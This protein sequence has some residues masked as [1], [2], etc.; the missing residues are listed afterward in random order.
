MVV[1][2]RLLFVLILAMVGVSV[3][4]AQGQNDYFA[5]E[6]TTPLTNTTTPFNNNESYTTPYADAPRC[7]SHNPHE[8][9]GLWDPARGCHYDHEHKH[10][11]GILY[12][13]MPPYER[14]EAQAMLNLFGPPGE[15]FGGTSISY[16]WQT[17]HGSGPDYP[18]RPHDWNMH[19]NSAKHGGYGWLVRY[20]IPN[21]AGEN[22]EWVKDFRLQYHAIMGTPGALVRYH[23]FTLEA[24]VCIA[25]KGC[26]LMR[27]GGWIDYGHLI[28]NGETVPLDGQEGD[29]D[30]RRLFYEVDDTPSFAGEAYLMPTFWYGTSSHA[31]LTDHPWESDRPFRKLVIGLASKDVWGNIHADDPAFNDLFCPDYQCNK[32]GSTI[33]AHLLHINLL[34]EEFNGYVDRY[35]A[36]NE[37]CGAAGLDCIPTMIEPGR[38]FLTSYRDDVHAGYDALGQREFDL[39]PPGVWW[40]EFPN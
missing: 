7:P 10:N 37:A 40:I 2:K 22:T 14:A 23:S 30:R 6:P 1:T 5:Y 16:P 15:W 11:P 36:V 21:Y 18:E 29:T 25:S 32:N 13:G 17:F 34:Q 35:G 33:Q 8:W 28:V 39:S 4:S 20:N 27:T 38:L 12:D 9:H 19:E 26:R 3:V 31:P 24:N